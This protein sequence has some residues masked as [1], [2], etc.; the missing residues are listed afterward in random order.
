[1]TSS[2]LTANDEVYA[3]WGYDANENGTPDVEEDGKYTLA[4]DGNAINDGDQVAGVP[5]GGE[6]KYVSGQVA[7]LD[8]EEPTYTLA[9]ATDDSAVIPRPHR[10]AGDRDAPQWRVRR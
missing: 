3:V 2:P 8:T 9:P 1:M 5:D 10:R 4:Y 6:I 7:V